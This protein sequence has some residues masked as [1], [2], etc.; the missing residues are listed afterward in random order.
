MSLLKVN[1][2]ESLQGA[3]G[4]ITITGNIIAN[5]VPIAGSTGPAGATGT[6]GT[7]GTSGVTGDAGTSG[8]SGTSGVTGD[9]GTSGSSGSSGSSGVSG[10]TGPTGAPGTSGTSAISF[11]VSNNYSTV[12]Y[13]DLLF[14][15]NAVVGGISGST[16]TINGLAGTGPNTFNGYQTIAGGTAN[17]LVL[18]DYSSLNYPD[19]PS[20][21][22]GGIPLGGVYHNS[23]ALRI[24]IS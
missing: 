22:T 15:P 19:D 20:A 2:I 17:T 16:A 7:S 9:A 13:P 3:T 11:S 18:E 5:G 12:G 23:G 1:Q 21:A 14:F 8:S 24:R 10:V 4:S 6:A